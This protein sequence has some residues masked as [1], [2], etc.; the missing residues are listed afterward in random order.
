[1]SKTVLYKDEPFVG[2]VTFSDPL[3]LEQEAAIERANAE[4][5]RTISQLGGP[6]FGSSA[7]IAA[8]LPGILMC[9]EKIQLNGIPENV[10]LQTWPTRPRVA[11]STLVAWLLVEVSKLY[12]DSAEP[13]APN[14][15]PPQPTPMPAATE[16][17]PENSTSSTASTASE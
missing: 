16:N 12:N 8:I 13:E 1:M 3:S 5:Q 7:L 15:L 2:S 4:M 9:L 11:V 10:T 17:N 14:A 6:Q